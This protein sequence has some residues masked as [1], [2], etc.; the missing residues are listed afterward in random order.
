MTNTDKKDCKG[1]QKEMNDPYVYDKCDDKEWKWITGR[2]L[3][4][5]TPLLDF[6]NQKDTVYYQCHDHT[7]RGF[8]LSSAGKFL[9]FAGSNPFGRRKID[10]GSME[11]RKKL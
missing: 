4:L 5:T 9:R 6:I 10:F 11:I 8:S 3:T 7:N 1:N 2:E